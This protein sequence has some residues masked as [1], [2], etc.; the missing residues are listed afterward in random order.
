MRHHGITLAEVL[1]VVGVTAIIIVAIFGIIL[2]MKRIY[3]ATA[4]H[5]DPANDLNVT[6]KRMERDFLPATAVTRA[7]ATWVTLIPPKQDSNNTNA[8]TTDA[9]GKLVLQQ[10]TDHPV[11][12]FVAAK[13]NPTPSATGDTLYR[14]VGNP[15]NGTFPTAEM[16]VSGLSPN[17]PVI[18]TLSGDGHAMTVTLAVSVIESTGAGRQQVDHSAA[19]T[20]FMR[21]ISSS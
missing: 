7:T 15:V 2:Q 17:V 6:L 8:I 11:H 21:N 18:F 4:A 14:A 3:L 16:L 20:F 9:S 13:G 19:T 12:Y 10:D 5:V 1:V